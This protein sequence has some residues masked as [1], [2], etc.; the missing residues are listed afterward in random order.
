MRGLSLL[1]LVV[2]V[3]LDGATAFTTKKHDRKRPAFKGLNLKKDEDAQPTTTPHAAAGPSNTAA[4]GVSSAAAQAGAVAYGPYYYTVE[5][6][7]DDELIGFGTAVISCVLSL[8]LGFGLGY[9]T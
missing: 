4:F 2:L 7:D 6:D 9:G 1:F 3:G 5:E 8:A